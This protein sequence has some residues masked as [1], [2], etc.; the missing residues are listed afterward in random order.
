MLTI[1]LTPKMKLNQLL[2]VIGKHQIFSHDAD[3]KS[4]VTSNRTYVNIAEGQSGVNVKNKLLILR[5][6]LRKGC[7]HSRIAAPNLGIIL[8]GCSAILQLIG[9]AK[10]IPESILQSRE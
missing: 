1:G 2:S 6:L 9:E 5:D 7:G 8:S 10:D 4:I 3:C